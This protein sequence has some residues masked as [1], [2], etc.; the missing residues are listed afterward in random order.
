MF[1]KLGEKRVKIAQR[2]IV[3]KQKTTFISTKKRFSS[4]VTEP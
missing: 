2:F 3:K 1:I 4:C